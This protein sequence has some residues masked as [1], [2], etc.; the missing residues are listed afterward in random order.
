MAVEVVHDHHIAGRERRDETFFGPGEE[1]FAV[2]WSVEHVGRVDP[3]VAQ[4]DQEGQSL[5]VTMWDL[6]HQPLT[7]H[8][9]PV[10]TGHGGL[11]P[12]IVDEDWAARIKPRLIPLQPYPH[13]G[14]GRPI[15]V[16]GEQAFIE[17]HPFAP[18]EPPHRIV[19]H[20]HT[21]IGPLSGHHHWPMP[22]HLPRR[23][24]TFRA[25]SL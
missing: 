6:F 13:A 25:Q 14:N 21:S 18:I 12:D 5:P 11:G 20:H 3:V 7:S 24:T 1:V 10:P 4:G 8:G 19:A 17:A 16:D 22:A 2:D 9:E 15:L 23:R